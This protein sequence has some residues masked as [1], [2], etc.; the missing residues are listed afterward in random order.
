MA[1]NVK[2]EKM[3]ARTPECRFSYAAVWKP[4]DKNKGK[5]GKQPEL[6]YR[7][8][9]LIPKGPANDPGATIKPLRTLAQKCAVGKWGDKAA[10]MFKD[11]EL[12]FPFKDGDKPKVVEKNPQ[13]AGHWFLEVSSKQP[14]VIVGRDGR[15]RITDESKFYS[16]CYGHAAINPYPYEVDGNKGISFGLMNLQKTKDGERFGGYIPPEETFENLGGDEGGDFAAVDDAIF[17]DGG[18]EQKKAAGGDG[19]G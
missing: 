8:T 15:T 1:D 3:W 9:L 14:P 2:N 5:K 10:Q 13:Y 11:G 6:V 16:G 12:K 7:T 17:G 4:V 19:W 18:G